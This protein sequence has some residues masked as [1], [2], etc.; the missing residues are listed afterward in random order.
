MHFFGRS[1]VPPSLRSSDQPGALSTEAE[2]AHFSPTCRAARKSSARNGSAIRST[3]YVASRLLRGRPY[4]S[5]SHRQRNRIDSKHC[6]CVFVSAF[7]SGFAKCHS[8]PLKRP[9][10]CEGSYLRILRADKQRSRGECGVIL[11]HPMAYAQI[12]VLHASLQFGRHI[13]D[14]TELPV[15]RSRYSHG[16]RSN[17]E[18]AGLYSRRTLNASWRSRTLEGGFKRC[19]GY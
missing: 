5:A 8:H 18:I 17:D 1:F 15:P 14:S 6:S 11:W 3:R 13:D 10:S 16:R 4:P 12:V 2:L 9:R 7:D 19:T